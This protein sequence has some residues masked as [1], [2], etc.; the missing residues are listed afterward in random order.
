MVARQPSV[1]DRS[2]GLIISRAERLAA[3]SGL[4][5]EHAL[6]LTARQP[7]LLELSPEQLM[8]Q[9]NRLG[10]VLGAD[11]KGVLQLLARLDNPGLRTAVSFAPYLVPDRLQDL[12]E[13]LALPGSST[14]QLD[15]MWLMV[16]GRGGAG[17]EQPLGKEFI[18]WGSLRVML[19][20]SS[21]GCERGKVLLAVAFTWGMIMG[22]DHSL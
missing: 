7:L 18:C 4:P 14:E 15:V 11:P 9:V 8:G 5:V 2:A 20:P 16:R 19:S 21:A 22:D 13:S 1:I 12:V 3:V 10:E 6:K 17:A